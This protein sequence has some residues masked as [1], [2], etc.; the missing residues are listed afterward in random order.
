MSAHL[1][2]VNFRDPA[3]PEAGGA[4]LHL[5]QILLEA[6]RRGMRVTW[7]AAGFEGGA[8]ESDHRGIRVLR[9]GTWWN[10][11]LVV[12]GVLRRE[13]SEAP[14]DLVI[15]DINKVPCFTPLWTAA[16]VA[17][18]VP[19]LFGATAFREASFPA[20]LY[21]V[22]LEALIPAVYRGSRFVA[23]SESTRDDLVRRGIAARDIAVVHCGVDHD[24]YRT[25]PARVRTEH[26][27]LVFVGRLR[28][29]KGLDWVLRAMPRVLARRPE[30]RLHVIG[31]GPH[32]PALRAA[33]E[34]LGI[35]N[36][37]VFEGYVPRDEKVRRIQS[38]WAVVQPSPKEGWG[39]TVVE[40]G[41]C[42]TAVVA[43][44]SPG[45]RDSVR[46]QRTGLLV[47]FDDDERLAA[48]LLAMIEDPALRD[49]L[50]AA[51]VEWAAPFTWPD[52]ARRSLD[53]LLAAALDPAAPDP[54]S[55]GAPAAEARA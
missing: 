28:R 10:F 23:I 17:V 39:L 55:P 32:G 19:H 21:V 3:H 12:P 27:T 15:E 43:A 13:M 48:A 9:R 1:V 40:A 46:D 41:A 50:G 42:G 38:A 47:P 36:A 4:E 5:E 35:A 45:L 7:L 44:D 11:N 53:A 52:C 8:P 26:P 37:V 18:I 34:R 16:P 49:R 2:A 29:Y 20:G 22:T 54:A 51:G 14:P 33:A 30:T 31:D 6:V 24:A 25:D